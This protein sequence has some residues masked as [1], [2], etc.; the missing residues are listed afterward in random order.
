M[1]TRDELLQEIADSLAPN[2][3]DREGGWFTVE[4]VPSDLSHK[5]VR[6]GLEKQVEEGL[7]EKA[8]AYDGGRIVNCYRR[9]M[10][11]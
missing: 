3:V 6:R 2:T 9:V 5:K 10:D 1:S 7:L 8:K 11:K 4:D